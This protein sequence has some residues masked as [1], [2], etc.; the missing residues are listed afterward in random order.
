ML[1]DVN[2]WVVMRVVWVVWIRGVIS[3]DSLVIVVDSLTIDWSNLV[4]GVSFHIVGNCLVWHG[5]IPLGPVVLVV[6]VMA[7]GVV[8]GVL[9]CNSAV[10]VLLVVSTVLNFVS[11]LMVIVLMRHGVV[12]SLTS[13]NMW[14][15]LVNASLLER[16][17]VG[18]MVWNINGSNHG[19]LMV[20]SW[21]VVLLVIV[22][23]AEFWVGLMVDVILNVWLLVVVRMGYDRLV[24][25]ISMVSV[26]ML[27]V[28]VMV[29]VVSIMLNVVMSWLMDDLMMHF[30]VVWFGMV[31]VV[32][33]HFVMHWTIVSLV[34][35]FMVHWRIVV[36]N[37]MN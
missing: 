15:D 13:F 9:E 28:D 16:S 5:H 14:L 18:V 32:H 21:R 23:V 33:W 17:M 27:M 6:T 19:M 24:M 11:N 36:N 31:L 37:V 35:R 1:L 34:S 3:V 4:G 2:N 30:M 7:V 26:V 22:V 8:V 12:L 29:V 25:D 10:L 20:V